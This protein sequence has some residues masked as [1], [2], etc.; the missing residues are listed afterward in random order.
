MVQNQIIYIYIYI[1]IIYRIVACLMLL[2]TKLFYFFIIN[3]IDLIVTCLMLL[4]INCF[5]FKSFISISLPYVTK[6]NT[7]LNQHI[8]KT[9]LYIPLLYR[10]SKYPRYLSSDG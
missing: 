8:H 5:N 4:E 3:F 2:E 9:A 10:T 1:I 6:S 7:V